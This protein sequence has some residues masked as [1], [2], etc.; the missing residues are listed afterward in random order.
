MEF[1]DAFIL[2]LNNALNCEDESTGPLA[3]L[4]L[5]PLLDGNF[6]F[7]L[8]SINVCSSV[9]KMLEEFYPD[10][11]FMA[12]ESVLPD[13]STMDEDLQSIDIDAEDGTLAN[14][15]ISAILQILATRR[16]VLEDAAIELRKKYN[17][18]FSNKARLDLLVLCYEKAEQN[19]TQSYNK[20]VSATAMKA[21]KAKINHM[22]HMIKAKE[23][24]NY[25]AQAAKLDEEA[26]H[27][28]NLQHLFMD[29]YIE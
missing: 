4:M 29:Q 16:F 21:S 12:G 1:G 15:C 23:R 6:G 25:L 19:N 20:P 26:I 27:I 17:Q 2:A 24:K 5:K 9:I 8:R 10:L 7:G 13:Q 18:I 28:G 3:E 11:A 22:K 14:R